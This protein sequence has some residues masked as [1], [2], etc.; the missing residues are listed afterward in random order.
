[1]AGIREGSMK[2]TERVIDVL[3]G[4]LLYIDRNT[5]THKETHRGG[6]IWEICDSCGMK[7]AD[8]GGGKPTWQDPP[9]IA[10]A[11]DLLAPGPPEYEEVEVVRW[12][13]DCGN[14]FKEDVG[15]CPVCGDKD[16]LVKLTGTLRRE[17]KPPVAR[18][19]SVKML[20]PADW[21]DT[22]KEIF[23]DHP[24]THGKTGTLTFTWE[25]PAE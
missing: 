5:C 13:C 19:V 2:R 17:K 7:W 11:R 22:I 25:E 15:E 1:M 4:L 23:R 16:R 9:E 6:A 20:I 18:S 8:D 14:L 10:A 21:L 3:R 24:E 12:E